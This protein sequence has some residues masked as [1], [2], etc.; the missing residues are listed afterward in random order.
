MWE[1]IWSPSAIAAGHGEMAKSMDRG[2]ISELVAGFVASA[3]ICQ[4]AGA[5]GAE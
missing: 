1:P 2:D 4:D 3:R 5:D